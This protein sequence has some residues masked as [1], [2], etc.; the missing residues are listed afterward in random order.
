MSAA[1]ERQMKKRRDTEAKRLRRQKEQL[2]KNIEQKETEIEQIQQEM[3]RPEVL[4]DHKK[5]NELSRR[6]D[7]AKS[8]LD[9]LYD[10]W[11]EL[12]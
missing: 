2:E 5:L 9:S 10:S 3:C 1:E 11:M 8:E 12:Q 7:E 6:L 4:S